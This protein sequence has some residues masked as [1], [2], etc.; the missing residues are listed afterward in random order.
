MIDHVTLW[1]FDSVLTSKILISTFNCILPTLWRLGADNK[2]LCA[3]VTVC[4]LAGRGES[5]QGFSPSWPDVHY[6]HGSERTDGQVRR[7]LYCFCVCVFV[8]VYLCVWMC[9]CICLLGRVYVPGKTPWECSP[10]SKHHMTGSSPDL[11][12]NTQKNKQSIHY[13]IIFLPATLLSKCFVHL[14]SV[15]VPSMTSGAR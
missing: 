13:F 8:S 12:T 5:V 3:T 10:D 14:W 9:L 2:C 4:V 11:S 6:C 1:T 7:T 15:C